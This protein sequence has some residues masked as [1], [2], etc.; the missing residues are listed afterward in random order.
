MILMGCF[1]ALALFLAAIGTYG[2]ISYSVIM[3]THEIGIRMA[4]GASR[5]Q[6]LRMI[7][8]QG[9]I[10]ALVGIGTGLAV[11]IV[12]ARFVSSLVYEISASDPL[13]YLTIGATLL[14]V[15]VVATLIPA[16]R[17]TRFDPMNALRYE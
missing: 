12:A 1:A 4:L 9:M 16:Y 3:R 2:V 14:V 7:L 13:T 15:A 10:L 6:V 11:A 5:R 17:A 8:R